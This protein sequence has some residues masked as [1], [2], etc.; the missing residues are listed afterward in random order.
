LTQ[1]KQFLSAGFSASGSG[2]ESP[3]VTPDGS[4]PKR[5]LFAFES[6]PVFLDPIQSTS[7]GRALT[8]QTPIC[9]RLYRFGRTGGAIFLR[10]ARGRKL[11]AFSTTGFDAE[12]T[13]IWGV[14]PL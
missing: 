8:T 5:L 14:I 3:T 1:N 7:S 2:N 4:D 9:Q 13:R 11:K 10:V 12:T 6:P